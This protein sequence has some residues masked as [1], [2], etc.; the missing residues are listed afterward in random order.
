MQPH[1]LFLL[2]HNHDEKRNVFMSSQ[3]QQR[4]DNMKE[5]VFIVYMAGLLEAS[6][7]KIIEKWCKLK[8]LLR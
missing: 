5:L 2:S 7:S 4:N 6:S 3:K 8:K 1:F